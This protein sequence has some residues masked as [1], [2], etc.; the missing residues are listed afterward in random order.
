MICGMDPIPTLYQNVPLKVVLFCRKSRSRGERP[1]NFEEN[2][3][4]AEH[5][6]NFEENRAPV[7]SALKILKKIVLPCG[8]S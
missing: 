4:R 2:F 5:P 8:A 7:R 1:E 6:E 3:S